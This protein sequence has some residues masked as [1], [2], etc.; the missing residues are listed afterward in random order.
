[1]HYNPPSTAYQ[2]TFYFDQRVLP[3]VI[4]DAAQIDQSD[5]QEDVDKD[6]QKIDYND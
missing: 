4:I 3:T 1:M 5:E 6:F 2:S